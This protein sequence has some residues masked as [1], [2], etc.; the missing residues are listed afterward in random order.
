MSLLERQLECKLYVERFAIPNTRR[1]RTVT[2]V[3]NQAKGAAG[4]SYGG[5]G[6]VVEVEDIEDFNSELRHNLLGDR[7]VLEQREVDGPEVRS[8]EGIPALI[9]IDSR[10]RWAGSGRRRATRNAERGVQLSTC[11]TV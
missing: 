3:G 7:R 11:T 4:R 8:R 6:E 1:S 9:A 2:S 10:D 5:V